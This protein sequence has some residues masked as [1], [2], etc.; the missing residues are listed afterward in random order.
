MSI[1]FVTYIN[2]TLLKNQNENNSNFLQE[3]KLLPPFL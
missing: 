1:T 3:R 2:E